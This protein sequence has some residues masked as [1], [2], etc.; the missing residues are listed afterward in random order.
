MLFLLVFLPLLGGLVGWIA[1]AYLH[2]SFTRT[3]QCLISYSKR[4][5]LLNK[6]NYE[7]C[8]YGASWVALLTMFITLIII[9]LLGFNALAAFYQGQDWFIS[10]DLEWIPLLGIRF[11]LILDG[12][13][14]LMSLLITIIV[15]IAILYSRKETPSSSGLFYFC[16]LFM[17]SA[18]MMSF[19]AMDL[20]LWFFLWEAIAIPVY[21][22]ITLWGRRDS[23]AQL[24]INGASKFL[25]YTQISSLL[26]LL[27]IISLAL[28]NWQLTNQW[29][30]DYYILTKT[31]ISSYVE[32]LLMLGF[33]AAFIIRIPLV[34]FHSWFIDAHIESSTTGSIM[35]SG[36]LVNTAIYGLLRF[37]IPL[38]PNASLTI[39]PLMWGLSLLTLFYCAFLCFSQSDIK[40]LIAYAHIALMSFMTAVVYS[41]SL[42]AYQGIILQIIS[43]SLVI[44]GLFIISGLLAERY[45]TRNISQFLGLKAHVKYLSTLTL[46]FIFAVLGVPGTANFVGNFM[47]LIGSFDSAAYIVILLIIGLILLAVSIII[48]MHPIFYGATNHSLPDKKAISPKDLCLLITILIILFFIGLYP[49]WVLD[50]S[51]PAVN[52]IQHIFSSAQTNLIEGDV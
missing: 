43:V 9:C 32:F 23:S 36:L 1:D 17:T 51:Y 49:Q 11:H 22:L 3:E 7:L 18:V 41:A 48:R 8:C 14:I 39:S 50:M 25:I 30:F 42:L 27:S 10:I 38:F 2:R 16:L 44:V 34:P 15:I 26:M 4:S 5:R 33:L 47:A 19:M 37:V 46:F 13:S 21:F 12:L 45:S 35:I 20:F 40:R 28:T 24:T 31:P 6:L 52:K 29:T